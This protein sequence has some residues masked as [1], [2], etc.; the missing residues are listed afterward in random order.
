[1]ELSLARFTANTVFSPSNL[2]QMYPIRIAI[3]AV[4]TRII[5][6]TY[7]CIITHANAVVMH[8]VEISII[9]FAQ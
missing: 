7:V 9:V 3:P 4:T 8:I 6:S 2:M 5:G 1:M